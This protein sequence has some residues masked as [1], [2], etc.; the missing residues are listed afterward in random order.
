MLDK[1]PVDLI[2]IV[3]RARGPEPSPGQFLAAEREFDPINPDLDQWPT[4]ILD[5]AIALLDRE[6]AIF[7][8]PVRLHTP[9]QL[10][11]NGRIG[12][13]FVPTQCRQ[14][15]YR[16][17]RWNLDDRPFCAASRRDRVCLFV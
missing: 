10:D 5:G 6:D 8:R 12:W 7:I 13:L 17:I 3:I 11:H 15:L 16:T 1:L 14:I 4:R 9:F 2:A